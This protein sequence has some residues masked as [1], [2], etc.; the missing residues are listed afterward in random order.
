[1]RLTLYWHP[2]CQ[3][4]RKTKKWLDEHQVPYE[5]FH[6]GKT[7]P[8]RDELQGMYE[9][10]GLELKNFISTSTKKYREL[11]IRDKIKVT[12]DKELLDL[13]ASDGML[14]KKPILTDGEKVIIGFKEEELEKYT[15]NSKI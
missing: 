5:L 13:L 8:S 3:T 2:Q 4:C 15:T 10:S 12:T 7:P 14:L 11:G 1:M 6:I 9:K